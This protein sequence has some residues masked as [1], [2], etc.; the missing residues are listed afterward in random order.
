MRTLDVQRLAER[1]E[2]RA[3]G[4]EIVRHSL[5]QRAGGAES[6]QVDGYDIAFGGQDPEH[7]LPGL[8]V[9]P[10]A[11]EQQQRL[12]LPCA[13][14]RDGQR[15]AAPGGLDGE[16]DLCGHAAAPCVAGRPMQTGRQ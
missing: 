9:V 1:A 6:G 14:I 15:V 13:L 8:P 2:H 5:G 7:R 12:T 10:Y 11:V 16:G 3:D 4:G